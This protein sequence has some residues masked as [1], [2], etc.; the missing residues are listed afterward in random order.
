MKKLLVIFIAITLTPFILEGS[1]KVYTGAVTFESSDSIGGTE[2]D[3][4]T[5]NLDT[6]R[7]YVNDVDLLGSTRLLYKFASA[8]GTPA[9]EMVFELSTDS[10][11]WV[12]SYTM[13]DSLKTETWNVDTF[14]TNVKYF[15]Y[16]RF[17]WTGV[18]SSNNTDTAIWCKLTFVHNLAYK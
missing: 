3:T 17:I 13:Q 9:I 7:S 11:N 16:G 18:S 15:K 2:A 12:Y 5:I 4:L 6:Y 8:A 10:T 14:P 1:S